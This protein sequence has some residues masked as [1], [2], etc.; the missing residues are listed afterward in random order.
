M[1]L[2]LQ[3][4]R[5][6]VRA[7]RSWPAVVTVAAGLG[8]A[9]AIFSVVNATLLG[10]LPFPEAGRLVM[11]WDQLLKLGI[12]QLPTTHK[13]YLDYQAA[14]GHL[15]EA[16]AAYTSSDQNLT[17][18]PERVAVMYASPSLLPLLGLPALAPGSV[19]VTRPV[20][21]RSGA[22][23]T[24][25]GAVHAIA[26]TLPAAFEFRAGMPASP[27]VVAPLEI[28]ADR[29]GLRMLARLRPGVSLEQARAGMRGIAARLDREQ[30]LYRGPKGEDAGYNILVLPL[31]EQLYG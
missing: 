19:L 21:A 18:N 16:L 8:S 31:Q 15:F 5:R 11:V 12:N 9:I 27:D 3:D 26:G 20:A 10:R 28:D 25:D 7:L 22:S 13:T 1:T 17:P 24:L 4:L 6:G 23:L 14:S 2:F 29:G 30:R